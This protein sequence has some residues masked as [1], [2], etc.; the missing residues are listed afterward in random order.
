[1]KK[2]F[3]FFSFAL[4]ISTHASA[5]FLILG[6]KVTEGVTIVDKG[7]AF[8]VS[9]PSSLWNVSVTSKIMA[10]THAREFDIYINFQEAVSKSDSLAKVFESRKADIQQFL[11]QATFWVPQET[12]Q[13]GQSEA[14]LMR[15]EDLVKERMYQEV[16]F[17]VGKKIYQ[18]SYVAKSSTFF[19]YEYEVSTI[20][21]SLKILAK[22]TKE[23]ESKYKVE[24]DDYN[25]AGSAGF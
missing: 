17:V 7:K 25:P 20:L 18:M 14:W 19:K 4:L 1:M 2:I 22:P 9:L 13:V 10:I 3:L 15:Y 23:A 21:D 12:R 6:E 24:E 8:Q 16:F 11:P 5:R